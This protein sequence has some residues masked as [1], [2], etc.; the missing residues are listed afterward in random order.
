MTHV[1]ELLNLVKKFESV[2]FKHPLDYQ[3]VLNI[4]CC[5]S[6][7]KSSLIL[8]NPMD[9]SMPGFPFPH[10]L[11]EFAQV[12]VYWISDAIQPSHPLLFSSFP[13]FN[14]S[15]HR[16]FSNESA[17]RIR[18]PSFTWNWRSFSISPSRWDEKESLLPSS[19]ISLHCN[20]S[21]CVHC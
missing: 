20:C 3:P 19:V 12:H 16:V 15:Q 10:Y 6:V 7:T 2:Y 9:C 14:L 4:C 1:F 17:L 13:A 18:F 8:C 21:A 5:F 11:Q